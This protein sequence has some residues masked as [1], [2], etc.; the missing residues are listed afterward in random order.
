[1]NEKSPV[2]V[3]YIQYIAL[4]SDLLSLSYYVGKLEDSCS[5]LSDADAASSAPF[6]LAVNKPSNF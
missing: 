6:L 5:T 4:T 2:G 1:M 3:I